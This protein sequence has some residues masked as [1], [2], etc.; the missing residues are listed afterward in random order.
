MIPISLNLKSVAAKLLQK[1]AGEFVSIK[2]SINKT[3]G[4]ALKLIAVHL[5]KTPNQIVDEVVKILT[6]DA[7]LP[8]E[9]EKLLEEFI[10]STAPEKKV[11]WI[12]GGEWEYSVSTAQKIFEKETRKIGKKKAELTALLKKPNLEKKFFISQKE[13][14]RVELAF[15]DAV[16]VCV[17]TLDDY[18]EWLKAVFEHFTH[19]LY[20]LVHTEKELEDKH[21]SSPSIL[22]L[23]KSAIE[24]MKNQIE[25]MKSDYGPSAF[26][27]SEDRIKEDEYYRE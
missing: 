8:T 10:S 3:C 26:T 17:Y 21:L 2:D 14:N 11:S 9:L 20:V 7:E 15:D 19:N 22:A 5:K 13:L 24:K 27:P 25:L 16:E 4:N 1:Y 12:N 18:E 6:P 23:K